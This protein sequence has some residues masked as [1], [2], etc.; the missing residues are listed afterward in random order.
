M[1]SEQYL[2]N[3]NVLLSSPGMKFNDLYYSSANSS[4]S[5]V[6]C[7]FKY[8]RVQTLTSK[9]F[10]SNS[11]IY[12]DR[13]NFI[14][15]VILH[16]RLPEVVNNQTLCRSWGIAAIDYISWQLGSSNSTAIQLQGSSL[17][18]VLA[19][20][21]KSAEK[22]YEALNLAGEEQLLP[23]GGA[24]DAYIL[25]PLP[26]SS[27]C[28]DTLPFDTNMLQNNISMTI[29][30]KQDPRCIYGGSATPVNSFS[31]AEVLYR[32]GVLSD[33]SKSLSNALIM[34]PDLKYNVPFIH[35]QSYQSPPFTGVIDGSGLCEVQLNQ[36]A[37]AD[38]TCI[39]VGVLLNSD[40]YPTGNN[41]P[42]PFNYDPISNVQ[43]RWGGE[44]IANFPSKIYRLTN[45]LA[46]HQDSAAI[47]IS[48]IGA[49]AVSPFTSQS[50]NAYMVVFDFSLMRSVCTQSHFYNTER[51]TNQTLSLTFNT[52]TSGQYRL[53]ATYFYNAV[54]EIQNMT[55]AILIA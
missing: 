7:S 32:Q 46:K 37:N 53:Y 52:S 26:F 28:D 11:T 24:T 17:V 15:D 45:M 55:S 5:M 36:F 12:F 4:V 27:Y 43:L 33:K 30:F 22:R 6:E 48:N 34:N 9:D 21:C 31:V 10:G 39:T 3:K 40:L 38:L 41:S 1:E 18:Q 51:L 50:K 29:Q 20:E 13:Q 14:G 2:T 49:G 16:L 8:P 19:A 44:L 47:P 35:K 54:A 42:R 25:I 23:G